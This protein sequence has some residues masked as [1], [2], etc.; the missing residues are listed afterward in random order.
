MFRGQVTVFVQ[1]ALARW[2]LMN[3]VTTVVASTEGDD[4]QPTDNMGSTVAMTSWILPPCDVTGRTVMSSDHRTCED[5][6]H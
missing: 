3:G 5:L 2:P 1:S 6:I 4:R